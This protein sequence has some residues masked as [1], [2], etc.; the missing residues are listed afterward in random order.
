MEIAGYQNVGWKENLVKGLTLELNSKQPRG[1]FKKSRIESQFRIS[2]KQKKC[3]KCLK[4]GHNPRS[5]R[6]AITRTA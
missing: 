3:E 6:N 1:R 2:T 4:E 5:C